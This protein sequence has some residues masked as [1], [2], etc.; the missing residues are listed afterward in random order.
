MFFLK[1]TFKIKAVKE[2]I[3]NKSDAEKRQLNIVFIIFQIIN[4][5]SKIAYF[6]KIIRIHPCLCVFLFFLLFIFFL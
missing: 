1:R 2:E 6:A 4:V 3:V 5:K